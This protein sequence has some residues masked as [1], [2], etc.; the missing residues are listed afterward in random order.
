[1]NA[2]FWRRRNTITARHSGAGVMPQRDPQKAVQMLDM[3][4]EFFGEEGRR[5]IR[6]DWH[7]P[8]GRR[9]IA[10]AMAYVG[11]IMNLKHHHA[12]YYLLEVLPFCPKTS[13]FTHGRIVSF[14][15]ACASYDEIR[16][17]ILKARELAQAEFERQRDQQRGHTRLG[18]ASA[19]V[20]IKAR[21]YVRRK[22]SA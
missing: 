12:G 2:I 8:S 17:V 5:W 15:D 6:G 11:R 21:N 10:G 7:D 22:L 20:Q 14:N 3:L 19:P 13:P 1:L 9:C 4:L 18:R 16:A